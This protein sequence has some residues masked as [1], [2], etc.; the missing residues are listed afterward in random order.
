[1]AKPFTHEEDEQLVSLFGTIGIR[2]ISRRLDRSEES[3]YRRYRE[4]I[5]SKK[6]RALGGKRGF[7]Y[8]LTIVV[9]NRERNFLILTTLKYEASR[10]YRTTGGEYHYAVCAL[11]DAEFNQLFDEVPVIELH[12]TQSPLD[13][14]VEVEKQL[15]SK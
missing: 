14:W 6:H 13:V 10:F 7:Q 5:T 11:S 2:Q 12:P 8:L 15:K 3:I 1:M 4:L 9:N